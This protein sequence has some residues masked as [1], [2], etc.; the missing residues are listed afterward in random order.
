MDVKPCIRSI[1]QLCAHLHKRSS[2]GG[3][4]V[5]IGCNIGHH[6]GC[7][8]EI[9]HFVWQE[10]ANGRQALAAAASHF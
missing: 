3:E 9:W 8:Y 1:W 10:H 6:N 4:I 2:T 5:L 7:G